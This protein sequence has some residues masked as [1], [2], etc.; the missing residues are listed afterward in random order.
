ML[1]HIIKCHRQPLAENTMHIGIP[2]VPSLQRGLAMVVDYQTSSPLL[3]L[4][5]K[6]QFSDA[7]DILPMVEV[8]AAWLNLW[9]RTSVKVGDGASE[10][11]LSHSS[12]I[13]SLQRVRQ[14]N[15]ESKPHHDG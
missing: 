8:L 9:S 14:Y 5:L 6:R 7:Q 4:A 1:A 13:P 3:R 11:K 10:E 15:L 12:G 2:A